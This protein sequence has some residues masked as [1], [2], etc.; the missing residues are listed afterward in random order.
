MA[1]FLLVGC[2]DT[3]EEQ[4]NS[5]IISD[6]ANTVNDL[7]DECLDLSSDEI[8]HIQNENEAT[9]ENVEID[10]I[11]VT[12]RSRTE[13][14]VKL[15]VGD[16]FMG[17]T[18]EEI[19]ISW[20]IYRNGEH[21]RYGDAIA[22]FSGEI[23]VTGD[24]SIYGDSMT[25]IKDVFRVHES[26][27]NYLPCFSENELLPSF[28]IS[29]YEKLYELVGLTEAISEN[30][31]GH[32]EIESLTIK[33]DKFVLFYYPTSMINSA[34]IIEVISWSGQQVQ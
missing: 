22:R 15:R 28:V 3:I 23:V 16:T 17:L 21:Y 9:Y 11:F 20:A 27:F 32:H 6:D 31:I 5:T 24:L 30:P 7:D 13:P 1:I 8:L 12:N 29:N 34:E 18:L 10:Y 25:A 2:N 19:D 33:I 26:S 14:P 4:E